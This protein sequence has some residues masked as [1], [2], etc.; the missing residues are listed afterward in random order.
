M[1]VDKRGTW[2]GPLFSFLR[3][4]FGFFGAI[5]AVVWY[6]SWLAGDHPYLADV[7][8]SHR[9]FELVTFIVTLILPLAFLVAAFLFGR[10]AQSQVRIN[11][12]TVLKG[13][14][15]G[16]ALLVGRPD[17]LASRWTFASSIRENPDRLKQFEE[18]VEKLRVLVAKSNVA[19]RVSTE[20]CLLGADMRMRWIAKDL[21][22]DVF[23]S[24]PPDSDPV[25]QATIKRLVSAFGIIPDFAWEAMEPFLDGEYLLEVGVVENRVD[26]VISSRRLF[27]FEKK[28]LKRAFDVQSIETLEVIG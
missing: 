1:K 13:L 4:A 9:W 27:T 7:I 23:S 26:Y 22:S 6:K 12:Q 28:K 11:G 14:G 2:R 5:G 10:L 19:P 18:E 15:K 25:D 3:I 20:V 8:D 21:F 17:I 24:P 16:H